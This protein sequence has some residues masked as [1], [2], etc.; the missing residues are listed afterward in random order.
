M[1]AVLFGD[2]VAAACALRAFGPEDRPVLSGLP[3]EE[4]VAAAR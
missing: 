1:R 4:A 3:V 2:G